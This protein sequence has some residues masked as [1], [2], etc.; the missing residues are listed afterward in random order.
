MLKKNNR[1]TRNYTQFLN[2]SPQEVFPLLCPVREYDWIEYWQCD[3]VYSESGYA[4]MD[5]IFKTNFSDDG[6]EDIWIVITYEANEKIELIVTNSNRVI[7]YSIT[8]VSDNNGRT[9]AEWKQVITALNQKGEEFI[10]EMTE[11]KYREEK[12]KLEEIFN[13]YLT[14][15]T[16]KKMK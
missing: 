4:E 13:H 15:K 10:N 1:I 14:T 2:G 11:E 3:I 7:R 8:L 9:I 12:K 5:C 6:T 16:M